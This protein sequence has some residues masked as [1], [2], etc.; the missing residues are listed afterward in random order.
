MQVNSER[1][2]LH[3]KEHFNRAK[4]HSGTHMSMHTTH[5]PSAHF[6]SKKTLAS[7]LLPA[8]PKKMGESA[9]LFTRSICDANGILRKIELHPIHSSSPTHLSLS[10]VFVTKVKEMVA[11]V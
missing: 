6:F 4:A 10:Q 11:G 9:K 2:S 3:L 1:F 7:K 8:H 5:P